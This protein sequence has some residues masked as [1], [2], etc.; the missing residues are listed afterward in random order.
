MFLTSATPSC[1]MDEGSRVPA[2]KEP[3]QAGQRAR[4]SDVVCCTNMTTH[5]VFFRCWKLNEFSA[6][7]DVSQYLRIFLF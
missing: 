7:R 3:E 1:W 6:I 2:M 5:V 4:S